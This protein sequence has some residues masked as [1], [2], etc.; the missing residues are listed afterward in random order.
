MC[1]SIRRLRIE[2]PPT[3]TGDLEAAALQYVRKISGMR[4]PSR[5]AAPAFDAAVAE[6]ARTSATLMMALGVDPV[7]GPATPPAL[8]PKPSASEL[9]RRDRRR[10]AVPAVP[11]AEGR[12]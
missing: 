1:R 2:T 4:A 12:A 9:A 5:A 3:T 8:W 7:D 11:S 10:G 6:I